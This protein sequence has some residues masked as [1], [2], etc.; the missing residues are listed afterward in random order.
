MPMVNVPLDGGL[1]D[2][3][4]PILL[5]RGELIRAE[6]VQ[7]LP[8]DP[9]PHP[10]GG[11]TKFN[12]SPEGGSVAG[13]VRVN[14]QT[15]GEEVIAAVG[16]TYRKAA[17][18][19][20]GTFATLVSGLTGSTTLDSIHMD[21]HAL[22]LN[23]VDRNRVYGPDFTSSSPQGMLEGVSAPSI[24]RDGSALTG[25][26]LSTGRKVRYWVE[27]RVKAADG[28]ILKRASTLAPPQGSL[29]GN[30]IA[31][32]TGDGTLDKPRI[33]IP[34][35]LDSEATHWAVFST[36]TD[37]EW[38]IG[39]EVGEAAIATLFIDDPRTGANPGLPSGSDY[40]ADVRVYLGL[41]YLVAR[42]GPAP[43]SSTGDVYEGSALQNDVANPEIVRW[44]FAG[45]LHAFPAFNFLRIGE[46][47]VRG[48]VKLI[49][50]IGSTVII[51]LDNSA[52]RL[53]G[54]P[55]EDEEILQPQ[56]RQARIQG[57][58]GCVGEMAGTL[59]VFNGRLGLAYV[60]PTGHLF[61][62]DGEETDEI[63]EDV[64]LKKL[65][66]FS[67]ASKFTLR[68]NPTERRLELMYVPI[69]GTAASKVLFF[70]Y[71]SF[72]LKPTTA[73]AKAKVSGPINRAATAAT[74]ARIGG[75]ERMLYARADGH[76]YVE[77]E[78]FVDASGTT[79]SSFKIESGDLYLGGFGVRTTV[80]NVYVHH[81]EA[82]SGQEVLTY[83][84]VLNADNDPRLLV[85]RTLKVDFAGASTF[86]PGVAA[87]G[88]RIL[89][90]SASIAGDFSI[91]FIGLDVEPDAP[92]R[93]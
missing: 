71:D 78:G 57:A 5:K 89:I 56:K 38:P 82:A 19:L 31:L 28:T 83:V 54:L 64:N 53:T 14:T 80:Q 75:I 18:A 10:T 27:A 60:S 58:G 22:L 29:E 44:S 35:G 76:V 6:D 20:T 62:T 68:D 8:D 88:H 1:V 34:S 49:R 48:T 3:R 47:K 33:N 93:R 70:A 21:G 63:S 50:V 90:E 51:C 45:N 72:H 37:G 42:H 9:A 46:G 66:D 91:N 81:S 36:E 86:A 52:W 73:G 11:R 2:T 41:E 85:P 40:E 13:L 39:A 74:N 16:T 30:G 55:P 67:Q 65:A 92:A 84:R 25:F 4:D 12:A 26:T 61:L 59:L 87:E 77:D 79:P 24:S 7:Y 15:G 43:V 23:G 17:A 32:L 69:G